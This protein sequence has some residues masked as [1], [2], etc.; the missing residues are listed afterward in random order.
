M[1]DVTSAISRMEVNLAFCTPSFSRLINPDSVP[2]L[3]TLAIGGEK[4]VQEDVDRW[5]GR[6]RLLQVYGPTECCVIC[7]GDEIKTQGSKPAKIGSGF[8]GSYLILDDALELAKP[9]VV[10]ELLIGGP[11]LA[12]GYLND[13]EKTAAS[14]I[15]TPSCVPHHMTNCKTW[16]KTGDLVKYDGSGSFEYIGRKDYQVKLR[17]QRIEVGEIEYHLRQNISNLVDLSVV[18][19]TPTDTTKAAFLAAFVCLRDGS[20]QEI[21]GDEALGAVSL[22]T[23][24]LSFSIVNDLLKSLYTS[25]PEYMVPKVYISTSFMPLT[26]AGKIDRQKLQR[27]AAELTIKELVDYSGK[28]EEYS[29]PQTDMEYRMQQLWASVLKICPDTIGR[30]D[31][32]VRLGGDSILAMK[33]V[34]LGRDN[35]IC[36]TVGDVFR[37]PVLF[38]LAINSVN[39]VHQPATLDSKLLPFSLVGG[40]AA[41]S[42]LAQDLLNGDNDLSVENISDIYPCTPFQ[43]GIMALSINYPGTYVAQ[44]VFELS[45]DL[46]AHLDIFRAAWDAIFISSP[47]LRTRFY[48]LK[49]ACLMQV[50]MNEMIEWKVQANLTEYLEIDRTNTFGIGSPLNRHAVVKET[51]K[52]VQTV[53]FVWTTH[54]AMY[55]AWSLNL[56]LKDVHEKYQK[57]KSKITYSSHG[58]KGKDQRISFNKF[59]ESLQ[60]LDIG[61]A[62]RFWRT[63]LSQ[64]EPSHYPTVKAGYLPLPSESVTHDIRISRKKGSEL[65]ISLIVQAA[66]AVAVSNYANSN[67]VMFGVT[68]SGRTAT[69]DL[70]SIVGPTITTVPVRVTINPQMSIV[71]FIHKVESQM[72]EMMPFEQIGL[73]KICQMDTKL[74]SACEFQNLLVIQPLEHSDIDN[75]FLGHRLQNY[76]NTQVFDTYALTME[77]TLKNDRISAKAIFDPKVIEKGQMVRIIRQ[78]EHI[79]QQFCIEEAGKKIQDINSINPTD[80][81]EVSEWNAVVPEEMEAC[82]HHLIK[83]SVHQDPQAPAICSWDGNFTRGELDQVASRLAQQLIKLGVGPETKVPLL[84]NKSKWAV[85]AM[86]AITIAGGAFVPL[87]PLHPKAR[88]ISIVEQVNATILL[89]ST[90]HE[91]M[92]SVALPRVKTIVVNGSEVASWPTEI[93]SM[94]NEAVPGNAFYVIFTSGTTGSPKG[95]V[96]EHGAYCSGARDHAKALCFDNTSR[97]LQFASY[98]FDTSVED[99][100]TTLLTGGCV[101]I[102]SEDERSSDLVGAINRMN[103]NTADLTPSYINS[104]QPEQ[105]PSLRRLT[106]GGESITS[107]II[108]LWA[109]RVHLI[110]AYGTT[111]CCVTS[112][113]N[114]DISVDTNPAN[115]GRAV[116]AVSWI[117]DPTDSNRLMPIGSMGELLIGGPAL[118]RG[119]LDDEK[120]TKA[121]FINSPSWALENVQLNSSGRLYKTG[122][123]VRYNNDGTLSYL[124]RKDTRVKL[125][126]LRIEL[127]EIEHHLL[128]HLEVKNALVM[129]PAAGPYKDHI[130]GLVELEWLSHMENDGNFQVVLNAELDKEGFSW[131]TITDYL[132]ERVPS[133]MVPSS[134]IAIRHMPLHT[135][136]KLDRSRLSHWLT[137]LSLNHPIEHEPKDAWQRLIPADDLVAIDISKIVE[138]LVTRNSSAVARDISGH[139]VKLSSAGMDSINIMTL[140]ALIKRTYGVT[141]AIPLLVNHNTTV[142]D[143]AKHIKKAMEGVTTQ[144]T[145]QIDLMAELSLLDTRLESVQHHIGVV[146]LTGASGFLG[147]QILRQLLKNPGVQKV[148]AHVR[149]QS[150][151]R[152][153]QRI[154]D[155]AKEARWWSDSLSSKLEIWIGDLSQPVLG[156]N[157]GQWFELQHVNAIIHNGASVK[158]NADY[159]TLKPANIDSTFDIL[160]AISG[161]SQRPKLVYVSGGRSFDERESDESIATKLSGLD[162]YSQTKFVSELMVRNFAQRAEDLG[163][164]HHI[165]IIKPGLIIG[166]AD[167][168]IANTDDFLWRYVAGAV[169]IGAY[170][171]PGLDDWLEVST[172]DNVANETISA[173]LRKASPSNCNINI[174][175]GV[176]MHDFWKIINTRLHQKLR[177]VSSLEWKT[178]IQRDIDEKVEAHHLWPV[179]HLL[180]DEGNLG[181]NAKP[182]GLVDATSDDL[183]VAVAKSLDFLQQSG[184]LVV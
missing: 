16:Y 151:E 20:G 5:F 35:G 152:G 26:T 87:E 179:A 30:Y 114:A 155:S 22:T 70:P 40:Q 150:S 175:N 146:F 29:S 119:Y 180:N 134:W 28:R 24:P 123:L 84:F 177:Q 23:G 53:Y 121:V 79:L 95:T 158:W 120:K 142:T 2:T 60:S 49:S 181:K 147:T 182:T 113:V 46:R 76:G 55:D 73:S 112:L 88:L 107:K 183:K 127:G 165:S 110:N 118:A 154:I 129:L 106:L 96:V 10:G 32:F 128:G 61:A 169:S 132:S 143:V 83:R 133:Y 176:A 102:P 50:V 11:H 91:S 141:V 153:R 156:L 12:R 82:V 130:T 124:G 163:Q 166:T 104:I 173:L 3:G 85:V 109:D 8:I 4:L 33:L 111:E 45:E 80:L 100:Y 18:I 174:I 116:G 21:K 125:R 67:D 136:G 81:R 6:V 103:V 9:G 43:E 56:T 167:E 77:C 38:K 17:G 52:G 90:E 57:L 149:A 27:I 178:M 75:S 7:I 145:F 105:V 98:S 117:V 1:N 99:I 170:P 62:E 168:G 97:F 37:T 78:F 160:R 101:C 51:I 135:S 74:K 148:I 144:P 108:K 54:H 139:D 44:H 34:A 162:G 164:N 42:L 25:L 93:S 94:S 137:G 122:D 184:F 64:G 66:W 92:C 89:C 68:L 59:V 19:A 86:M 71:D 14:F 63:E 171:Q 140:A 31:S 159:H 39:L 47:I 126:G 13:Q 48:Q 58:D 172:V 157:S 131:S 15:D 69:V 115:I 138:E 161:P 72:M 65:R 36:L 41:V